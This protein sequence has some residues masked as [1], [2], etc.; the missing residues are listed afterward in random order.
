LPESK[1][2]LLEQ[3]DQTLFTGQM[4]GADDNQVIFVFSEEGFDLLHPVMVAPYQEQ[5][6]QIGI[7]FKVFIQQVIDAGQVSFPVFRSATP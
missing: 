3:A 7:R 2:P 5:V 1:A 6:I 4:S